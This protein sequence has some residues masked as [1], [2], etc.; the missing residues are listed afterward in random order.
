MLLW[1][2]RII[3]HCLF[4]NIQNIASHVTNRPELKRQSVVWKHSDSVGKKKFWSK[5]SV[6]KAMLTDLWDMKGPMTIVAFRGLHLCWL[7]FRM[8]ITIKWFVHFFLNRNITIMNQ[9]NNGLNIDIC[10]GEKFFTVVYIRNIYFCV[11]YYRES[12]NPSE[13]S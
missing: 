8:E 10:N 12:T 1:I 2:Y 9:Y 5:Q 3:F 6:K 4:M 7:Y 11:L 13:W